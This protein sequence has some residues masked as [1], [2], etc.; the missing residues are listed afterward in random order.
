MNLAW[1][2]AYNILLC[3]NM[4]LR[5]TDLLGHHELEGVNDHDTENPENE[6]ATQASL[7][8]EK[9]SQSLNVIDSG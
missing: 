3:Q 6:K 5:M 7:K 1:K 2:A 4:S 8:S 9:Q